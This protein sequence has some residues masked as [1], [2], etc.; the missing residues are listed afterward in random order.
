MIGSDCA[1]F[2]ALYGIN[3]ISMDL[4]CTS[5]VLGLHPFV[6]C[7]HPLPGLSVVRSICPEVNHQS[8]SVAFCLL[9]ISM[10]FGPVSYY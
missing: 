5:F 4:S 2:N 6:A 9:S 8:Q 7:A 3:N 1:I 10:T